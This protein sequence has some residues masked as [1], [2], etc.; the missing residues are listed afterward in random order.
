MSWCAVALAAT[1]VFAVACTEVTAP[2]DV[3]PTGEMW[4]EAVGV[5]S[6]RVAWMPVDDRDVSVYRIER[7]Q[8]FK[9][10]W[11]SVAEVPQNTPGPLVH[12]DNAL[13]PESF[14]GYRIITV[15]RFGDES[16]S[17]TVRGVRTPP[18]PGVEVT[19][20][21]IQQDERTNAID[22]DGYLLRLRGPD[23]AATLPIAPDGEVVFSPVEPG[24]YALEIDSI[25]VNCELQAGTVKGVSQG[26]QTVVTVPVTDEGVDTRTAVHFQLTCRDPDLGQ[27]VV[28]V[29]TTGDS[30]DTGYDFTLAGVARDGD[31]TV[32][33]ADERRLNSTWGHVTFNNLF[34]GDYQV[35]IEDVANNCTVDGERMREFTTEALGSDTVRYDVACLGE[36]V[37]TQ[38]TPYVLIHEWIPYQGPNGGSTAVELSLDLTATP[39]KH[40]ASA[41]GSFQYDATVVEY[42]SDEAGALGGGTGYWTVNASTPGLIVWDALQ[43]SD[44]LSGIVE[45]G[46]INFNIIGE[47]ESTTRTRGSAT[48][49]AGP[50]LESFADSV[51]VVDDTLTV[52][53]AAPANH[54]PVADANGPYEGLAGRVISFTAAGSS[55]P[56]GSVESYS[57]SFGD[58]AS[59]S[60][61]T[62]S[63][64]FADPGTYVVVL[65][66]ADDAGATDDDTTQVV[67]TDAAGNQAPVAEANG[68]YEGVAGQGIV[69]GSGGSD[70]PDGTITSYSWDFGD[71]STGTGP[72]PTHAYDNAGTY[73]VVLTVTDDDGTTAQDTAEVTVSP[74]GGDDDDDDLY[75]LNTWIPGTAN[76]GDAVALS[77]DLDMTSDPSQNVGSAEGTLQYEQTVV[78]YDS[79]DAGE[80]DDV[81]TV[82]GDNPG[83]VSWVAVT[84]DLANP[85]T[86]NVN[87]LTLYFTVAGAN[88]TQAITTTQLGAVA[89]INLTQFDDLL[90]VVEDTLSVGE[91]PN[92]L[93]T[94]DA[95][96]P[97]T[98]TAGQ[99][100]SFD[101]SGSSDSDGTIGSHAWDFGDDGTGSGETVS[102][103][104][105]S[106]GTYTVTLTVTDDD[107]ATASAT[108]EVTVVNPFY[109]VNTWSPSSADTGNAVLLSIDLDMTSDP[110]QTVGSAEGT[111][112]YDQTVVT[113]DSVDPGELDDVF[114]VNA[115]TP[116]QINWVAVTTD[117]GTPKT[118][119]VSLLKLHFTVAGATGTRAITAT[120]LGAVADVNLTQFDDLIVAV[121]DTLLVG[122]T[123]NQPP[124][125]DA[126]GPYDATVGQAISFDGSGSSDADGTIT[127]FAWDF[128][129]GETGTGQTTTH[130]YSSA[131]NYTVTLT[132]TDDDGATGT[133]TAEVTVAE[134]ANQDPIADA[135]GPYNGTAGESISFDGSGS[136]DIH[137][138]IV[139]YEWDFGDGNTGMGETVTHTYDSEGTYDVTLT[140]TDDDG[141]TATSTA[142]ATVTPVGREFVWSNEFGDVV[143]DSV[144]LTITLDLSRDIP[145]TPGVVEQL[146]ECADTLRWDPA[147]LEYRRADF[148]PQLVAYRYDNDVASGLFRFFKR[149][150]T[151]A[152]TGLVR[153]A[154]IWF[155][156]VGSEG[157]TT[158]TAT[159]LSEI[160]G[161]AA[162]GSF[163]YLPRTS[164]S[165]A[166][167][168]VP[169]N[170]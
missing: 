115:D 100:I 36:V 44:S 41:G 151:S 166:T 25:A 130:T 58:G 71:G 103:T 79:V 117:L 77:I 84:T 10:E 162:T 76:T 67:A 159:G 124:S 109:L 105:P 21:T 129:D 98:G 90:V 89:D 144:A 9:G 38:A 33:I 164:V 155:T 78:T 59:D 95:G 107:G 111:L 119:N 163:N 128:G 88:G 27:L 132:V 75:L 169:S 125:S 12:I 146:Y 16:K 120:S 135:G 6:V 113:Y 40:V 102:H 73:E 139:S 83:Q 15:T 136:A 1:V 121:E 122:T 81:F 42:D 148:M 87:L 72:S 18:L 63:H 26:T 53:G 133:T 2:S 134:P 147:V 80:L 52:G 141:A 11:T 19:T 7:R 106:A 161:T 22:A 34:P 39:G 8:D 65:T 43:T 93:P 46:R 68:P 17:S 3:D 170:P 137:G 149:Q 145:E 66:V 127:T 96:G 30:L 31:S 97:Y 23:G 150:A 82:N 74:S 156:V 116:G 35:T 61:M 152:N 20:T 154:V 5:R 62:V 14:Y 64:T 51:Y 69:F 57:W 54:A 160:E 157:A 49:V 94:A 47:E 123:S 142:V 45:I 167:F 48:V 85:N 29:N 56:D 104:Y 110:S 108:T 118:G 24:T 101:G 92:E 55:D 13:Q 168:T 126:G 99:P 37:D 153:I 165:E 112:Q 70:D 86:G 138:T 140:V 114:T 143:G 131:G 60:G 158:T 50:D 91:T 4:V 32:T 28:E